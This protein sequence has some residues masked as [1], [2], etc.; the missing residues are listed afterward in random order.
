MRNI[1]TGHIFLS[2]CEPTF[3]ADG[4]L[5]LGGSGVVLFDGEFFAGALSVDPILGEG[6]KLE[7][8]LDV[9]RAA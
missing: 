6:R 9:E 8:G 7:A 3:D 1:A 4:L 5:V 2:S